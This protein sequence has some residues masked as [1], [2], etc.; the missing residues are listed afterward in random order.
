MHTL[1]HRPFSPSLC[2]PTAMGH[3]PCLTSTSPGVSDCGDSIFTGEESEAQ[4]Y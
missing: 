4:L 2:A 1:Q 3:S